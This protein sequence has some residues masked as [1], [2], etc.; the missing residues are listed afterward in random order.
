M[1]VANR[2]SY[3]ELQVIWKDDDMIELRISA[4]N[5]NFSGVTEVYD[6]SR[7]L[8]DFSNKLIG[9]PKNGEALFHEAG[10]KDSYAYFSMNYYL[11]DPSGLVGVEIYLESNESTEYRLEEKS[12]VKLEILVEP[13]AIDRFQKELYHLAQKEDGTAILYGNDNVIS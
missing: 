7:A 11:V 6:M 5:V 8:F 9:F 2:K 4:S 3:L 10:E 12:K 1:L 13:S